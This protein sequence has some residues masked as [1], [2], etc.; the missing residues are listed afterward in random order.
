MKKVYIIILEKDKETVVKE[1]ASLGIL[2]TEQEI[3]LQEEK[4]QEVQKELDLVNNV[5][6]IL[7]KKLSS[8]K[9]R[10]LEF[11]S[12]LWQRHALH[13]MD[14]ERRIFQLEEYKEKLISEMEIYQGWN[15]FEPD[16]ILKLRENNLYLKLYLIPKRE[17][18]NI[19]DEF[20]SQEVFSKG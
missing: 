13:I 5:I 14:L 18:K 10:T 15:D 8:P 3:S 2:H 6:K 1:L 11:N 16:E 7:E 12:Q 19:P 9:S 17:K 4:I 20:V